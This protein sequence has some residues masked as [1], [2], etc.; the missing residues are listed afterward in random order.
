MGTIL[1]RELDY[2]PLILVTQKKYLCIVGKSKDAIISTMVKAVS[3]STAKVGRVLS[4]YIALTKPRVIELLLVAALPVMLLADRGHVHV[5][6]IFFTLLGG[7]L[8]AASA[9]TLNMV[10]DAD[11]DAKMNRTK[12]RPL[13]RHTVSTS[14]ALIFGIVLAV[15]S[16]AVLCWKTNVFSAVLILITILFY[17]FVYTMWLKRRTWQNVIW[18]GAAGCMPALI[19][20]SAQT[21][22]LSWEPVVLFLVIFLWTPPHT[23]A[24][25]MHYK[26]DYKNA[27]VPMLP[28]IRST[29]EVTRQMLYYTVA[30]VLVSLLLIGAS[31]I[32]YTVTA[33]AIGLWFI[34]VMA[35]TDNKVHRNEHI[36]PMKIFILSNIYLAVLCLALSVD[37]LCNLPLVFSYFV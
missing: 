24:L 1:F 15:A 7:W 6:T 31:G 16:V 17:V 27:G 35:K 3:E 21:G 29:S 34:I 37:S 23:W 5:N 26:E 9:N 8:G 2:T 33:I 12:A 18:G 19:G 32:I 10:V 14:E 13:A 28:V 4:A 20:W 36:D 25:A 11:I 30:T 22:G